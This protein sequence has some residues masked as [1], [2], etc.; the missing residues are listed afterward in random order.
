LYNDKSERKKQHKKIV[1]KEQNKSERKK[2][3]TKIKVCK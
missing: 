2:Q 1:K 3:Q